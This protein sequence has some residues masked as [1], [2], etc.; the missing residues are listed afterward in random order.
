MSIVNIEFKAQC[1]DHRPIRKFLESK[2]ARFVG[3]DHQV[4]TYFRVNHG[5]LKLRQGSIENALIHYL[6]GDAKGLKRSDVHLFPVESDLSS[7]LNVLLEEA[8][9]E[10]VTVEK[11][12]EIYFI[13]NVKF[14]LDQVKGLGSFVEVE[15]IDS[16]GSIGIERLEQQCAH[17]LDQLQI[18]DSAL[19]SLS[20]SDLLIQKGG[21][22]TN[23]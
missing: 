17:Y 10:L 8:L 16:E 6:R 13:D 7:L 1:A 4:D 21:L 5:R 3:E 14:H 22:S 15:A 20:Y 2:H 9:G 12:R 19:I 23:G 11:R 18:D